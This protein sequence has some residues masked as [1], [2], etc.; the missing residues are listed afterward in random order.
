[1]QMV[2]HGRGPPRVIVGCR[3]ETRPWAAFK[4]GRMCIRS[5]TLRDG[6]SSPVSLQP[7]LDHLGSICVRRSSTTHVGRTRYTSK[8]ASIIRATW[9]PSMAG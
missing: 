3:L 4:G 9:L 1:M 7:D 5:V 8:A 6:R 2:P